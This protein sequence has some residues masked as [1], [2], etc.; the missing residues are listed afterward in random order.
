MRIA[1]RQRQAEALETEILALREVLQAFTAAVLGR[2]D[3]LIAEVR[4]ARSI[5]ADLEARLALDEEPLDPEIA[6]AVADMATRLTSLITDKLN[7]RAIESD[8][9]FGSLYGNTAGIP[10]GGPAADAASADDAGDEEEPLLP[11]RRNS[12]GREAAR[13]EARTLYRDLARR[14][15]PDLATSDED[16]VQREA[17][18]QQVNRAYA[19]LDLVA[20][21]RFARETDPARVAQFSLD[22][23]IRWAEGEIARL[24]RVIEGQ[25]AELA[26]LQDT[27]AYRLWLQQQAG[28]A[29]FSRVERD[30]SRERFRL[31]RRLRE[32]RREIAKRQPVAAPE[33]APMPRRRVRPNGPSGR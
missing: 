22:D 20:L 23:K 4:Y 7:G 17:V 2:V 3:T 32:L 25:T 29:V 21:R 33:P 11:G 19:D 8:P 24:D 26:R 9:R 31:A 30:L 6:E 13:R 15:H 10:L 14:F 12:P 27:R 18:M 1:V 5:I 16:R 28:Q